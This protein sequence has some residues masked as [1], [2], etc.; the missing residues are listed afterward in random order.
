MDR[1]HHI[2]RID[3][4]EQNSYSH[5]NKHRLCTQQSLVNFVVKKTQQTRNRM[6]F[7][8]TEKEHPSVQKP[9]A[10]IIFNGERLKD[11][12]SNQKDKNIHPYYFY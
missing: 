6:T 9:V 1:T 8:Q 12:S 7:A 3:S 11:F 5:L 10:N 2:N 4:R